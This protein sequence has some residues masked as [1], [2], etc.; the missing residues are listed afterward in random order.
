MLDGEEQDV[1]TEEKFY[2]FMDEFAKMLGK[3][4][5]KKK[6]WRDAIA[7]SKVKPEPGQARTTWIPYS[8]GDDDSKSFESYMKDL[9]DEQSELQDSGLTIYK[10]PFMFPTGFFFQELESR[11]YAY[12]S[13]AHKVKIDLQ[14]RSTSL[15]KAINALPVLR[16]RDHDFDRVLGEIDQEL[17]K[18]HRGELEDFMN[19]FFTKKGFFQVQEEEPKPEEDDEDQDHND[20]D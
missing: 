18:T 2:Q 17:Q 16:R 12:I 4:L 1:I 6:K 8:G 5:P 13:R 7:M 11:A 15:S 10:A 9:L 14:V 3:E 19:I 20:M